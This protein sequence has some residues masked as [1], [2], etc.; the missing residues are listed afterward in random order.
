MNSLLE[1]HKKYLSWVQA[2]DFIE[3]IGFGFLS[4]FF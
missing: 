4:D 1:S 3:E 2:I